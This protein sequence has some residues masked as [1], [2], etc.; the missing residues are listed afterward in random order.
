[1][2]DIGVH[3]LPFWRNT[4]HERSATRLHLPQWESFAS[5]AE[6]QQGVLCGVAT[7]ALMHLDSQHSRTSRRSHAPCMCTTT[8][9]SAK[10]IIRRQRT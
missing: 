6:S 7:G 2:I 5:L 1:M 9:Y 8:S 3:R 10:E 4:Y